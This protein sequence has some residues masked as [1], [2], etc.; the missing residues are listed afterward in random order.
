MKPIQLPFWCLRLFVDFRILIDAFQR[1]CT[2]HILRTTGGSNTYSDK[3]KSSI[4]LF[5]SISF[6]PK[7]NG[8]SSKGTFPSRI[9]LTRFVKAQRKFTRLFSRLRNQIVQNLGQNA[10][11]T[12]TRA[13]VEGHESIV[14]GKLRG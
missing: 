4:G 12:S 3:T 11:Q 7:K 9:T 6:A 10:I 14:D 2:W 5:S 1:H 13:V 8:R